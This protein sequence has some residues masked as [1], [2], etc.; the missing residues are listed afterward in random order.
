MTGGQSSRD[1]H[2]EGMEEA[3]AMNEQPNSEL[4]NRDPPAKITGTKR[5]VGDGYVPD[6]EET[7]EVSKR[8]LLGLTFFTSAFLVS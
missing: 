6:P 2:K 3:Q 4:D 5:K 7:R 1:P 8:Q